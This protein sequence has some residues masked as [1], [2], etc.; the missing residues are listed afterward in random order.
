[1]VRFDMWNVGSVSANGGD[2][3]EELRRRIVCCLR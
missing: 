1:M 2:I 3:C